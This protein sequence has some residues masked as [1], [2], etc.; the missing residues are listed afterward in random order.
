MQLAELF[1]RSELTPK[2]SSDKLCVCIAVSITNNGV[3]SITHLNK[4]PVLVAKNFQRQPPIFLHIFGRASRDL[5]F[6][7]VLKSLTPS[8]R[9]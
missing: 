4:L 9:Y 6:C 2:L 3:I 8:V 1:K 7:G 5:Q